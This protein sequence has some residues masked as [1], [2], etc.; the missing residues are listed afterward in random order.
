MK[1]EED[2]PE[3][4][5]RHDVEIGAEVHYPDG[6]Q[7]QVLISN[8]SLDGCRI[9]G[10]FRIGEVLELTIPKIGRVRGQVRW[11]LAGKAG[12]RFLPATEANAD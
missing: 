11:A 7:R 9:H 12:I 6:H 5:H 4:R 1:N 8:L 2:W 3:R 10:W